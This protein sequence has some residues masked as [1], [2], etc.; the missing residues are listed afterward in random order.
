M[1]T[2]NQLD[3]R[4]IKMNTTINTQFD[5]TTLPEWAQQNP[6]I[7]ERCR[8]D[9]A[10]RANVCSATTRQQANFLRRDAQRMQDELER[11]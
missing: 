4:R 3:N 2:H 7:V 1:A 11:R 8:T 5:S 10:F 9:L 6:A